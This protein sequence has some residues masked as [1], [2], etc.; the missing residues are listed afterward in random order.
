MLGTILT[1]DDTSKKTFVKGGLSRSILSREV[2]YGMY[3]EN[4]CTCGLEHK[5]CT[6]RIS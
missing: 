1:C 3:A 2:S 5:S 6:W 4:N